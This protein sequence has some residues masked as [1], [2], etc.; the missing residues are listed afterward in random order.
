MEPAARRRRNNITV[1]DGRK[2]PLRARDG[3]QDSGSF[4]KQRTF[5]EM[6]FR[7]EDIGHVSAEGHVEPRLAIRRNRTNLEC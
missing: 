3:G 6:M 5:G 4:V 1:A 7:E 2:G